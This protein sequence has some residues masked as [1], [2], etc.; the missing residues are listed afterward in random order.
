[1]PRPVEFFIGSKD[2][3]FFES[4]T[5]FTSQSHALLRS[6]EG[7]HQSPPKALKPSEPL[8]KVSHNTG[9]RR[10]STLLPSTLAHLANVLLACSCYYYREG[11]Q[12]SKSPSAAKDSG[13]DDEQK[14]KELREKLLPTK[15]EIKFKKKVSTPKKRAAKEEGEAAAKRKGKKAPPG[16]WDQA[17][18]DE[19]ARKYSA[20]TL[21]RLRALHAERDDSD[22]LIKDPK[23]KKRRMD[24]RK[25]LRA[26]GL[27]L[28]RRQKKPG[29][30]DTYK[31]PEVQR[32]VRAL[33]EAGLWD[34]GD[35]E[36][37]ELELESEPAKLELDE[38]GKAIYPVGFFF[39]AIWHVGYRYAFSS[40]CHHVWPHAIRVSCKHE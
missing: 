22:S 6:W 24:L 13:G 8:G 30:V 18:E 37:Y 1:M 2:V 10:A 40:A 25:L 9:C 33:I 7:P 29:Q 5:C 31:N 20:A 28:R 17:M 38:T 15:E 35:D 3:L 39:Y 27:R 16:D 32:R 19:L 26:K 14:K 23:E 4:C 12:R 21:A 11:A 34:V 36:E